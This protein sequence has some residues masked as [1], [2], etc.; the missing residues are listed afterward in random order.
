VNGICYD[1]GCVCENGWFGE[2]CD[3]QV[4]IEERE[5]E[6]EQKEKKEEENGEGIDEKIMKILKEFEKIVYN[7]QSDTEAVSHS[8][9]II[10]AG[11]EN[12]ESAPLSSGSNTPSDS[13]DS[14]DSAQF[15]SESLNSSNSPQTSSESSELSEGTQPPVE[16]PQT[17]QLT[18]ETYSP[19]DASPTTALQTHLSPL[20]F[21][22]TASEDSAC[23]N[24]CNNHGICKEG[25][26]LCQKGYRGDSCEEILSFEKGHS[27][28]IA[29][30]LALTAIL[31]GACVG[32]C[33]MAI[34][35][36]RK[37]QE[38]FPLIRNRRRN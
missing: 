35:R 38:E 16:S 37:E 9:E 23:P 14:S 34:P 32:V 6:R 24:H 22:K 12:D 11:T 1:G 27:I 25:R 3:R 15:A 5:G 8:T 2:L 29:V 17:P 19:E 20:L 18:S 10:E 30:F 31:L 26:C 21:G 13:P 33:Y 36:K 4:E 7:P 28:L